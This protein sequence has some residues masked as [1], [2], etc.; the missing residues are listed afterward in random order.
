[1]ISRPIQLFAAMFLMAG[2]S[3]ANISSA[4]D[5]KEAKRL[6]RAARFL[7][8]G[9]VFSLD[10]EKSVTSEIMGKTTV[11]A[12]SIVLGTGK[13]RWETTTPE[14]SLL[15]FDGK[16]VWTLQE[17]IDAKSH[18][19]VT[20]AKLTKKNKDQVLIKLLAHGKISENFGVKSVAKEGDDRILSLEPLQ[21]DP[22]VKNFTAV[23]GDKPERLK[24]IRYA[25]EL[26]NLTKIRI[27]KA[28]LLKVPDA[29]VFEFKVPKDAQVTDL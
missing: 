22:S 1:M 23:L 21:A 17:A 12:G 5:S 10:V 9:K 15:L 6:D 3:L 11:S 14:K 16:T 26:G 25:D 4:T 29:D 24:E 28:R 8:G 27:L 18:P 7:S 19:Q 13:F 20:K 2:F